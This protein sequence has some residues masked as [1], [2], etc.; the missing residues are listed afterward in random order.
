MANVVPVDEFTG[1][2]YP[3]YKPEHFDFPYCGRRAR[4]RSSPVTRTPS[5]SSTSTGRAASPRSPP[6]CGAPTATAGARR[7]RRRTCRSRPAAASPAGSRA[8]TSTARRSP[9]PTPAR[10]APGPTGSARTCRTSSR[11]TGPSG[12][13]AATSWRR[14]G[15]TSRAS[16]SPRCRPATSAGSSSRAAATTSA[17][18]RST[19]TSCTRCWSTSSASTAPAPRWASTPT[20]SASSSRARTPRSWSWTASCTGSRSR[21]ARPASR[22]CSR[23]TSPAQL[24]AALSAHGGSAS[25]WL[26][27][28]D[29]FLAVYGHRPTPPATSGCPAGSRTTPTRSATSRRFLLKEDDHDF[30]AA[31]RNALA[32]ARRGHRRRPLRPHQGGAGRVRRRPGRQPGRELPVVAGRPQLL[33]RPQGH[34]AAAARLPGARRPRRTPTTRT[35]CSTCSGRSCSTS[36]AASR[37]R[38]S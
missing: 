32:R 25:Q 12:R 17:R 2:W 24:R 11:T 16:T 1:E 37:T 30:E 15:T 26:T 38:A 34:A 33:H 9:R 13:R 27:D 28:F 31:A 23:T 5:G 18:W 10:S 22:R 3:G 6:P 20:W 21:P 7:A 14:P 29:D 35:T 4:R 36:P 19:S 8:P